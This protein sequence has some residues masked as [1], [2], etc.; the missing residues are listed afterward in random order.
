MDIYATLSKILF[1]ETKLGHKVKYAILCPYELRDVL[2]KASEG[3]TVSAYALIE[4]AKHISNFIGL[5]GLVIDITLIGMEKNKAGNIGI[6]TDNIIFIELSKDIASDPNT[7]LSVLCHELVHKFMHIHKINENTTEEDEL[8]TD[9]CAVYL[10]LGKIML[11]GCY[12]EKEQPYLS[13]H[14]SYTSKTTMSVGY[15]ERHE[16]AIAY[17]IVC[18]MRKIDQASCFSYLTAD[19]IK[20]L[21]ECKRDHEDSLRSASLA[22]SSHNEFASLID[23]HFSISLHSLEQLLNDL[24]VTHEKMSFSLE[25]VKEVRTLE[26]QRKQSKLK[27]FDNSDD[28]NSCSNFLKHLLIQHDLECDQSRDIQMIKI[29]PSIS[30]RIKKI[31]KELDEINKLLDSK[32]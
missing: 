22:A 28:Y 20:I 5:N 10:G 6:D 21:K 29:A 2:F 3:C 11:T 25:R 19:V 32:N 27:K 18:H 7:V 9:I 15:L 17:L 13:N 14:G 31:R 16:F 30:K 26:L 8:L 4:T 1:L 23:T 12:S 24:T